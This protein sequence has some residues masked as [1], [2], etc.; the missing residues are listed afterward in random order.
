MKRSLDPY[1][2]KRDP[3]RTPEPVPPAS[4]GRRSPKG[5]AD[6]FVIQEH[7]ATALHWDFRLERDG[8]LVSWAL[9]KGL[10]LDPKTNHLAVHTEDHPLEYL[11]FSGTIPA[12][13][14]GG[15]DVVLWDQGTYQTE[16]WRDDEVIVVLH[17]RRA[18]G[19][20]VLFSTRGNQWMIHRM[21][22]APAGYE[23]LPQNLSPMLATAGELPRDSDGWAFEFKW[24]GIRGLLA[25]DGG[26]VRATS[27]NGRDIT[28]SYPE[29]RALGEAL[30]SEQVLLDA[31]LV[32]LDDDGR[33]SFGRLQH[34]MQLHGAAVRRAAAQDP[35]SI[36]LFDLLHQNGESLLG[37][38]YDERR[39][40]LDKLGLADPRWAV[41]P[42]F[43]DEDPVGILRLAADIGMEGIVAKRRDSRYRPGVRSRDWRKVKAVKTQEVVVGGWTAGQGNRSG[44]F[45]AL[46]CGVPD[47]DHA[48]HLRFVGKVGTGFDGAALEGIVGALQRL[49]Q[50]STPFTDRLPTTVGK[51][52][53][54]VRPDLVGEVRYSE[55]TRDGR[56]RHPVWRG[57]RPDKTASEVAR[58]P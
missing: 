14:Y 16:K 9:P 12:G 4:A 17:G 11:T 10:P 23:P 55:W 13:E 19:R 57:L 58:E 45:G 44:A 3:R 46:L 33:P 40:R 26:R 29:L 15:G 38:S 31:E 7:H 54:W 5:D 34:R 51:V 42:A 30:G 20:Y 27:R 43:V 21:D 28:E 37:L 32:V 18:E 22:P 1:R 52:A 53:G 49:R 48:G 39:S 2:A 56:L 41:T 24:D 35:V 50:D 47:P 8:V 25:V 36:V 6:R